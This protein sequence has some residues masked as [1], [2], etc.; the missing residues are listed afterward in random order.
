M[1]SIKIIHERLTGG[2]ANS[3]HP[4][5]NHLEILNSVEVV[6]TIREALKR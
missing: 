5:R 3:H 1:I 2:K 6:K 4:V